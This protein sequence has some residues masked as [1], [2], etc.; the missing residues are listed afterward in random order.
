MVQPGSMYLSILF[1]KVFFL[2]LSQNQF[3]EK[4]VTEYHILTIILSTTLN[5][6]LSLKERLSCFYELALH[7]VLCNINNLL[8]GI[9]NFS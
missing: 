4:I 9:K 6:I 8:S 5:K 7:D 3:I 2:N 1:W